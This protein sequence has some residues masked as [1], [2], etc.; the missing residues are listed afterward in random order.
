[1]LLAFAAAAHAA[2]LFQIGRDFAD[3]PIDR[4]SYGSDVAISGALAI[5][6][7]SGADDTASNSGVAYLLNYANPAAPVELARFAPA[8][9]DDDDRFG[10]TVAI[11]GNRAAVAATGDDDIG[12]NAGTVY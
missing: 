12:S 4:E 11:A 2:D 8:T 3:A 6:G 5:V 9:G 7:A 10:G 1:I